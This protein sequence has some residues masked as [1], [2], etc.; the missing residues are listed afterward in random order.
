MQTDGRRRGELV[1]ILGVWLMPYPHCL[2]CDDVCCLRTQVAERLHSELAVEHSWRLR[3]SEQELIVQGSKVRTGFA[4]RRNLPAS[5]L[6]R[7]C[8]AKQEFSPTRDSSQETS[9]SVDKTSDFE[10]QGPPPSVSRCNSD[11]WGASSNSA[12]HI[13]EADG[14]LVV[15]SRARNLLLRLVF[16]PFQ[17]HELCRSFG[18]RT[19][20]FV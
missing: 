20:V 19:L 1:Q 9:K 3:L 2:V 12:G 10:V 13:D 14:D 5:P 7:A 15:M 4:W 8:A 16:L 18:F 11:I 17:A 6:Y